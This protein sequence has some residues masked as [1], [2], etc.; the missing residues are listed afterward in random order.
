MIDSEKRQRVSKRGRRALIL[1]AIAVTVVVASSF[2]Y[3]YPSLIAKSQPALPSSG[4]GP[5]TRAGDFVSYEFVTPLLGWALEAWSNR[6]PAS[7]QF[8]VWR[9]VD[10]AKHWQTQLEGP[11]SPTLAGPPSI[12]FFDKAHGF[13]AFGIELYRTV[14]GGLNWAGIALPDAQHAFITFADSRHGWVLA[15]TAT[16]ASGWLQLYATKDAGDSWQPLPNPP[17]GS[18]RMAFRSPLE[19]WMWNPGGDQSH[20]YVSGDAGTSWQIRDPPDPPA[21]SPGQT[22]T[23]VSLR[24]LPQSGV[25]AYVALS[26]GGGSSGYL[27]PSHEFTSFDIGSSWKYVPPTPSQFLPGL[28][29][30]EDASRWWRIDGGIVYKSSDSGQT[31]KP[32]PAR[33]ENGNYWIYQTHVLDSKHAWAQVQIGEI[34][35]LTVTSDGGLHW[36]RANVPQQLDSRSG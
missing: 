12:Q 25:V 4:P 32:G 35:G 18:T 16:S 13:V 9:T 6:S 1:M 10:G 14:D 20:L 28:E 7:G 8:S 26:E 11:I 3:L 34:T 19:G 22:A 36:T 2:A 21:Q 29:G 23:V 27:L 15:D 5:V 31:W 17:V 24:L 33:L 30:F